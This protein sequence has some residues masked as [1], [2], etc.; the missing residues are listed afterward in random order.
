MDDFSENDQVLWIGDE[1]SGNLK[2][3][4]ATIVKVDGETLTIEFSDGET[5]E[6]EPVDIKH[7]EG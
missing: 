7:Y 6:V 5:I 2:S 4:L 1:S 3:D